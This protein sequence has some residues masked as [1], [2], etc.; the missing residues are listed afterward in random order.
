MYAEIK[1]KAKDAVLKLIECERDGEQI[2]R[3]LVKNVLGI[4]QE[5]GVNSMEKYDT[6]FEDFL[7][8]ETGAFYQRKAAIWVQ[9]RT[10]CFVA[11]WTER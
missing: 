4:F 11:L 7:L 1:K 3:S 6:D 10:S 9:V 2:N 8:A 5:V